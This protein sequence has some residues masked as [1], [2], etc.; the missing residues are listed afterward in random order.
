LSR[1]TTKELPAAVPN[2]ARYARVKPAHW[3]YELRCFALVD[4][5]DLAGIEEQLDF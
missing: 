1:K 4:A 2:I 5:S 3:A